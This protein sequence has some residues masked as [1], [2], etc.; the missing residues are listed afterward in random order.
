MPTLP[1]RS[2][3]ERPSPTTTMRR[4]SSMNFS[5]VAGVVIVVAAR[6]RFL[7]AGLHGRTG[8]Y[9]LEPA[10]QVGQVVD[11]HARPLPGAHPRE[12]RDVGDGVVAGEVLVIGEPA[13]E[14]A[15]QPLGLALIAVD[16]DRNPLGQVAIE[17]VGLAHHRADAG[18]LEHEPLHDERAAARVG[19][20]QPAGLFGEV[21][22]DRAGLEHGEVVRVVVDQGRDAAVRVDR[23]VPVLLLLAAAE[24]EYAHGPGQAEFLERDRDLV[25][26]RR[27]RREDFEHLSPVSSVE[28]AQNS[29]L[30]APPAAPPRRGPAAKVIASRRP[31]PS[32][33][34]A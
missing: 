29:R 26:V 18:H 22:E 16:R 33:D 25:T 11:R 13:I 5:V 7:Q 8:A 21:D 17:D 27:R 3:A 4:A 6:R 12:V 24:V 31:N 19:R 30:D 28:P 2:P 20:H 15:E 1:Q 9:L 23:E 10:L 14:H 34:G 32:P